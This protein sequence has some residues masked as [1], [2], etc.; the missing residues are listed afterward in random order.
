MKK[1]FFITF[2]FLFCLNLI[3]I[4]VY[5]LENKILAKVENQLISSFELKNKIKLILFLTNQQIN[6]KN[7]DNSKREAL[8]SLINLKLKKEEVLKFNL[9]DN[10]DVRANKYVN[11]LS[12]RYNTD[13]KGLKKI[14]NERGIDYELF[15]EEI[16]IEM[17]W[18]K[19]I[20]NIYKEKININDIEIEEEL[21]NMIKNNENNKEYR[22]SEIEILIENNLDFKTKIEEIKNQIIQIGFKNTAIKFSSSSTALNGG[23]LGWINSK[24]LS[25]KVQNIVTK[26]KKGEVSEPLIQGNSILF[27]KLIDIRTSRNDI[28]N[29]DQLKKKIV[30]TKQNDM[31]N[32]F[33]NNHLSKIRNKALI[34]IQ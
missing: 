31:L 7:V 34:E 25:K 22:L 29:I 9:T 3:N 18:Q 2:F 12:T 19:I 16:K 26:I 28:A 23:D 27:L 13:L 32:L 8:E 14:F 21:K 11:N 4:S 6:Q 20:Y 5:A 24:T 33:S 17:G 30:T 1:Y 10:L 15:F